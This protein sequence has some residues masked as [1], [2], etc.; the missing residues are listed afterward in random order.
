MLVTPHVT[1]A[2]KSPE[3]LQLHQTGHQATLERS[4]H[5]RSRSGVLVCWWLECHHLSRRGFQSLYGDAQRQPE[6]GAGNT[7]RP[8]LKAMETSAAEREPPPH[9]RPGDFP[10]ISSRAS[11]QQT[12][13][14]TAFP[15]EPQFGTWLEGAAAQC[16]LP[17]TLVKHHRLP[18][19]DGEGLTAHQRRL[20]EFT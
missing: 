2:E 7:N 11:F 3:W 6:G 15:R 4:L 14:G 8:S 17:N 20:A 19:I 5:T 18:L 9:G 10:P 1:A 16:I 12:A 13:D